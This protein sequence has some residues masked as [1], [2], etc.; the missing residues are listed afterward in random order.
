MYNNPKIYIFSIYN[1][2]NGTI[3]MLYPFS[4][5]KPYFSIRAENFVDTAETLWFATDTRLK[6]EP[7]QLRQACLVLH[8]SQPLTQPTPP[9]PSG[10]Q[11]LTLSPLPPEI[12]STENLI[13]LSQTGLFKGIFSACPFL[14]FAKPTASS[15]L[16]AGSVIM[17]HS[18]QKR[19]KFVLHH[20]WEQAAH[21]TCGHRT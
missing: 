13:Q 12:C 8:A 20:K 18:H 5:I 14:P 2:R 10:C 11:F 4:I 17:E 7:G 16:F 9:H 19:R 6:P 3:K 15:I 1:L 21:I